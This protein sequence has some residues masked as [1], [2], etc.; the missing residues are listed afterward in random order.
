MGSNFLL[1][2]DIFHAMAASKRSE[3]EL[4]PLPQDLSHHFSEVTKRR[5]PSSIKEFYR[6]FAIPNIGNLGGG[7]ISTTPV[8]ALQNMSRR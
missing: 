8:L 4:L 1:N 5:T 2:L 6:F 7:T 3:G